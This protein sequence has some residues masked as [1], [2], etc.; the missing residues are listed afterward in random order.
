M[1]RLLIILL[2]NK[3][4]TPIKMTRDNFSQLLN[5]LSNVDK[6][7]RQS[8]SQQIDYVDKDESHSKLTQQIGGANE[9][10]GEADQK[11]AEALWISMYICT[12]SVV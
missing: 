7:E 2:V 10:T 1:E 6:N 12:H 3:L 9:H 4:S 5:K 8:V 11:L